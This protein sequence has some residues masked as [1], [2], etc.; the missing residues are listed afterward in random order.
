MDLTERNE[1]EKERK[2]KQEQPLEG[3]GMERNGWIQTSSIDLEVS[4]TQRSN[5]IDV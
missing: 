5:E 4:K 2:Q 1:K 3:K